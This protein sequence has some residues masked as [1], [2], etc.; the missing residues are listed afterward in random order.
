MNYLPPLYYVVQYRKP[1]HLQW[2]AVSTSY[3]NKDPRATVT[4]LYQRSRKDRYVGVTPCSYNTRYR[5]KGQWPP[6]VIL[7]Q[8]T[9]RRKT[10]RTTILILLAFTPSP[11]KTNLWSSKAYTHAN[12]WCPSTH[13]TVAAVRNERNPPFLAETRHL[14]HN[15]DIQQ[16]LIEHFVSGTG[17]DH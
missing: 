15:I 12:L 10:T 6:N 8:A 17:V 3:Y 11:T 7:V 2:V 9:P 4:R 5:N 16:P 14:R 13:N 1:M